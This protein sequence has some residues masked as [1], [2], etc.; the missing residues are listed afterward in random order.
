MSKPEMLS[1]HEQPTKKEMPTIKEIPFKPGD[2]IGIKNPQGKTEWG[3]QLLEV[4]PEQNKATVMKTIYEDK[5]V[6]HTVNLD[7]LL[8]INAM[9]FKSGQDVKVREEDWKFIHFDPKEGRATVIKTEDDKVIQRKFKIE[10]LKE[11]NQ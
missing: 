6:T 1:V 9:P 2:I 11:L 10:E 3:W 8:K 4:K 7:E 5:A